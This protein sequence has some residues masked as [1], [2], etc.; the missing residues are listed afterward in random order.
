MNALAT[1]VDEADSI[2]KGLK[3]ISSIHA[4]HFNQMILIYHL[5]SRRLPSR[6]IYQ[7]ISKITGGDFY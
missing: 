3:V 7:L 4:I 1:E 2:E 6:G 5:V